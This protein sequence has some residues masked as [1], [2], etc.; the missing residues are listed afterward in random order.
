METDLETHFS[1]LQGSRPSSI[2]LPTRLPPPPHV[3]P[4]VDLSTLAVDPEFQGL[5]LGF[6]V[7]KLKTFGPDL[8]RA[9]AT[10]VIS[11]PDGPALPPYLPCT[12][13]QNSLPSLPIP[14]ENPSHILA[15]HSPDA[16]RTLLVPVHGLLWAAQSPGL[17]ILS[18]SPQHQP[19]STLLPSTSAPTSSSLPVLE[20][21]LPS[22]R[23][24][25][26]LQSWIYLA[27]PHL[28]LKSL[29]PALP[30]PP[31]SLSSLLNPAPEPKTPAALAVALSHLPSAT[32]LDRVALVH[33][34]WQNTVAL[35]ISDELIWQTMGAAWS[36]LV[37]AL[38][39]QE[40][41]RAGG[42]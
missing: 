18:S 32:L 30:T 35:E 34:L 8:L 41:R 11:I 4:D 23:A 16:P 39:V 22:T 6:V 2:H 40:Q 33:G 15:I 10:T 12:F 28:L 19:S 25:P 37:A 21:S 5:P 13:A 38:G 7:A 14:S 36:V 17:A 1:D 24:V 42:V 20:L 29:L 27:S 3:A 26:L 31:K 9:A